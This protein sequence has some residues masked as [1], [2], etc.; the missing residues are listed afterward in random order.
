[1]NS[2]SRRKWLYFFFRDLHL[3]WHMATKRLPRL[4]KEYIGVLRP[5]DRGRNL[6]AECASLCFVC[7]L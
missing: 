7:A 6:H 2:L 1:M 5:F 3:N 4:G